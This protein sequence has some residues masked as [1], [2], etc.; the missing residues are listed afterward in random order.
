MIFQVTMDRLST[1]PVTVHY[2]TIEDTALDD[3]DYVYADDEVTIPVGEKSAKVTVLVLSDQ[4]FELDETFT[5]ALSDPENGYLDEEHDEAEGT[6]LDESLYVNSDYAPDDDCNCQCGD[7]GPDVSDN[8]G[9][10]S[11]NG[12]TGAGPL[13]DL[14]ELIYGSGSNP[15]PIVSVDATVPDMPGTMRLYSADATLTFGGLEPEET[16]YYAR[17]AGLTEGADL[18][19]SSIVDATAL[20]TG[21][22]NWSLLVNYRFD[23]E[24]GP[25]APQTKT[26]T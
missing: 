14:A 20:A 13:S 4:F 11:L 16:I 23:I 5:V 15:H 10:V 3:L 9:D 25:S 26:V 2:E 17:A 24:S 8:T 7:G 18:L 19:L 12:I 6:I 1:T 22:Y 21:A